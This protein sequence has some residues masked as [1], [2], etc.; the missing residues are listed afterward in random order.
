MSTDDA[1]E[2]DET[3]TPRCRTCGRREVAEHT[4]DCPACLHTV[5]TD[6]AEIARMYA[7]LPAEVQHRGVD[8]G[9]M[10]LLGPSSDPEARGHLEASVAA[11]RVSPDM[12]EDGTGSHPLLVTET[13]GM[14]V[15]DALG[16]E[17]PAD[18]AEVDTAVRYLNDQLT[19]LSHDAWFPMPDMAAEVRRCKAHMESVLHDG[20]QIERGAP[21]LTC[22]QQVH[23]TT[24]T[25]GRVVYDCKRCRRELTE[26]EYRLAVQAAYIAH[27]D[28]L[29]ASDLA[30]R[31]D[32]EVKDIRALAAPRRVWVDGE[33]ETHDP[34]LR[35]I[36]K[37]GSGRKVY[38]VEKVEALLARDDWQVS[39]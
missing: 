8:S 30:E 39:A 20:E 3:T 1:T 35:S 38:S 36:G 2:T 23:R 25:K 33:L 29:C 10:V 6:L 27:A 17:E 4:Y 11:G 9:A 31:L 19:T 18:R 26:N 5:R 28:R 13:W 12:L 14:V 15:R 24:D 37:D 32:V 21:C 7:H 34:L 22:R 16:H